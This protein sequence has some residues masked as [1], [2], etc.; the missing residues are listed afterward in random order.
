VTVTAPVAVGTVALTEVDFH[1]PLPES[2]ATTS[3]FQSSALVAVP[4]A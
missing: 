2:K 3:F 1:V 4:S